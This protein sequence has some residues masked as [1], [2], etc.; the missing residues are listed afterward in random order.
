M[1]DDAYVVM[2]LVSGKGPDSQWFDFRPGFFSPITRVEWELDTMHIVLPQATADTLV[3]N[4][5][6]RLMTSEERDKYAL[7]TEKTELK[8]G[9]DTS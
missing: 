1:T 7:S 6:A 3:R 9:G 8:E 2:N 4:G 5:Y